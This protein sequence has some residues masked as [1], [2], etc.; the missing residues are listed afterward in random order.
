MKL[1]WCMSLYSL[2]YRKRLAFRSVER[3]Y[4]LQCNLS[5]LSKRTYAF[6]N[7]VARASGIIK[8]S[9]GNKYKEMSS[10]LPSSLS[11]KAKGGGGARTS[12]KGK[13]IVKSPVKISN[14]RRKT[15]ATLK[16]A[17]YSV[18]PGTPVM[19]ILNTQPKQMEDT[20]LM[21]DMILPSACHKFITSPVWCRA[22]TE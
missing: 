6:E 1:Y 21:Q 22:R 17:C 20:S 19:T 13:T 8:V 7:K 14:T 9:P 18:S 5:I 11:H 10:K 16:R 2:Y 4:S 12:H 15:E 3:I